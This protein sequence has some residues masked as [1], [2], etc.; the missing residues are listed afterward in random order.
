M[1]LCV[2]KEPKVR[3]DNQKVTPNNETTTKTA[4]VRSEEKIS[5][6]QDISA[7][8]VDDFYVVGKELGRGAFSVVKEG[9][10]KT[11]NEKV[12]LKY[13]EKKFVKKKHIEQLRREIDIMKKVSHKNVLALKEIFESDSHLTLVMELVTG[14]ELFY[15]IV[16]RGSFTEKD[17]RNVVRQVCEGVEYLHSQGIAHRD[18]KP[19]NLLCSGDGEDMV[20]KIADFGLSKIFGGG[21]ALETS[22]GTPDYVAPEVL[23]G[24]SYDNAVDMWS[25]G[26]ITYILLCGF[27]PFYASSQN[28]LFEKILTA[29]YDFPEPEWTHVSENAKNFI[30]KLIVKDPDQRLTAKKCLE[31]AWIT[32]EEI[33]QS[34]LHSHF[35]E[36]M[37]KYND[38]R[39]NAQPNH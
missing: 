10:R 15:K 13:I 36:K 35:A 16:E 31:D 33:N 17:A 9:T 20:I 7:G 21:E 18:L 8:Q 25:I 24:G 34:D 30:K 12:A 23:T 27:P 6:A 22:C 1:G 29:D 19:E 39:K 14:G 5:S 3:D 2:S 26:V 38:Q 28:L 32:G 37:K 4:E 11:N